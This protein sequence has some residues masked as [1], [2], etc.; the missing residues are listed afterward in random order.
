MNTE[1]DTAEELDNAMQPF[2]D[3][4][5]QVFGRGWNCDNIAR[6]L[7]ENSFDVETDN[8]GQIVCYTGLIQAPDG[9]LW[10]IPEEQ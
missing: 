9:S 5:V 7:E 8:E 1:R 3:T 2:R 10:R 4:G 6:Y